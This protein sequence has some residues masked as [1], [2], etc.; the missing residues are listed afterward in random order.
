MANGFLVTFFGGIMGSSR[1]HTNDGRQL[2][3][4]NPKVTISSKSKV[5]AI[6]KTGA[7]ELLEFKS[8]KNSILCTAEVEPIL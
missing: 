2:L 5:R 7:Q 8:L 6:V 4:L 1:A 3:M